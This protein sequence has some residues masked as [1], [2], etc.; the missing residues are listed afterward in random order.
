MEWCPHASVVATIGWKYLPA[1]YRHSLECSQVMGVEE[2]NRAFRWII[3]VTKIVLET[4]I[5]LLLYKIFTHSL[6][7]FIPLW[8]SQTKLREHSSQEPWIDLLTSGKG[9]VYFKKEYER[10]IQIKIQV[11]KLSEVFFIYLLL[12]EWRECLARFRSYVLWHSK[13]WFTGK[14]EEHLT[15]AGLELVKETFYNFLW[16]L[17][18][19][20]TSCHEIPIK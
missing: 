15:H 16:T 7:R 6:N 14:E 19:S 18:I 20:E 2:R 5:I 10:Y 9:Y 11:K 12:A 4:H 13:S 1:H 8:L 3:T 17:F